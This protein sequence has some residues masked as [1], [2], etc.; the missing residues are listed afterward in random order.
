MTERRK[1]ALIVAMGRGRVIGRDGGLPWRIPEDLR[2][3]KETTWG[4]TILM[5][6]RTFESIGRPLPGRRSIVLSRTPEFAPEGVEVARGLDEALERA[7]AEDEMPFVV[8]GGAVYA[9]ALPRATHL[10]LTEVDQAAKGDTF[11]PEFDEAAWVERWRRE[12]RT[13]GVLFRL[14]E[15]RGA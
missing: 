12:G 3:F 11:F 1:L 8:G 15:R 7:W 4:H 9:E 5:G 14:L 2:H 13:P 10:Y 6:R